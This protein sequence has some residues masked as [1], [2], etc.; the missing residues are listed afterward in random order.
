MNMKKISFLFAFIFGLAQFTPG[1][2]QFI[3]QKANEN[4]VLD[5][6]GSRFSVTATVIN[7]DEWCEVYWPGPFYS[8][9]E[10]W[11]DDGDADDFFVWANPGCLS[12]NK[13]SPFGYPFIVTGGKVYVGDGSFPGPF[14]GV[15]FR[16]LVY[17]DDG[18]NGLPGTALDSIDV[19]V[20][21]YGWV[22]FE[23]LTTEVNE[24]D[25]YLAIKQLTSPP[26]AA[27]VGVDLDNPT[28][29]VSYSNFNGE[30][31]LSPLQDLMIRA[32]IIG[33]FAPQS[34]I[35]YFEVAR[36]SGFDPDESPL[37][38][39]TTVLEIVYD[40]Y[41]EDFTWEDLDPGYYA[42]GVKTHFGSGTWSDY[43]V[44][45]IVPHGLDFYPPSCFYQ[46][47]DSNYL[48]I[49]PPLDDSGTIPQNTLGLNL[50]RDDEFIAY[51]PYP[52][53]PDIDTLE[54]ALDLLPGVY[55]Y[56]CNAV[57]DLT[58]YGYPGETSESDFV[59]TECLI[60]YGHSLD[61]VETWESGLGTN[62]WSADDHW[63][64]SNLFG[65]PVPSVTFHAD[66]LQGD[67]NL[68]LESCP[69]LADSLSEGQVFLDYDIMLSSFEASET[70]LLLT[71]VWNWESRNW[72]TLST[73]S[74]EEGSF[75]WTSEHL[76][77]SEHAMNQV[78]MVRFTAMGENP[79]MYLQ[80]YLDNI[81]IYRY[82]APPVTLTAHGEAGGIRLDWEGVSKDK[83]IQWH[84]GET[85]SLGV[86][87][88]ASTEFDVAARWN[89]EQLAYFDGDTL[90]DVAFFPREALATYR[91]RVWVGA[92]AANLIYDT[93][94]ADPVINQWNYVSM[95]YPVVIDSDQE[96]WVGYNVDA[97][98]GYPAGVDT[99][100]ALDGYGNM[101][102]FGGWQTL[103]Q[104]NP[105]LDYNW[106][107]AAFLRHNMDGHQVRY[108]IYR[109]DD[110]GP[111]FLRDY[112]DHIFYLDDSV[113]MLPPLHHEYKVTA[114]HIFETDT[115]ESAFSNEVYEN[116]TGLSEPENS[117]LKIYPNPARNLLNIE[118]S[119]KIQSVTIFDSRGITME[120]WI[121]GTMDQTNERSGDQAI[122]HLVELPVAGLAPGLYL[123]R[124][125]TA[126]GVVTGKVV[127]GR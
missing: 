124:V 47:D 118:S 3:T 108:A 123:V 98:T 27:P 120:Q 91:I 17:D 95:I 110:S 113:C 31:L 109:S 66:S 33:Y 63:F 79:P 16:V 29:S 36:F 14:L 25:F 19:T 9:W 75:G 115:C 62:N 69:F 89:T 43:D 5:P 93:E 4:P 55:E 59:A 39:D 121:N 24:G 127:V 22:E 86:G 12:A 77:I 105:D 125:V 85:N 41:Y 119:E 7:D 101:I 18:D 40:Y 112:A 97:V 99:G 73:H 52:P 53:W 44:S 94:V 54:V 117:S 82:C 103:K 83:W 38:G 72:V 46:S 1:Y 71:Q 65:N 26:D 23:G 88:G 122:G 74:N 13:F 37:L 45:N 81:H 11:Y 49:C 15:T 6:G 100:P 78:F 48:V 107:I 28:Y 35:D 111:Y 21:N 70:E 57:Y 116:C 20:A 34:E 56:A 90:T 2:S 68:S 67:Y 76:D 92:G 8:P 80:W 32:W 60:R 96:L 126:R 50:Y 51:Y 30:W 58:P 84:N 10:L 114:L 42:Y 64:Q 106:N 61:F 87:T 102:D 104:I